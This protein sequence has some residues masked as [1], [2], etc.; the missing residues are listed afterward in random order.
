[1]QS[2]NLNLKKVAL[3]ILLIA[4]FL[5]PLMSFTFAS[6][7]PEEAPNGPWVDEIVFFEEPDENKV[8]DMLEKGDA[9][10]YL[11]LITDPANFEKVKKSPNIDYRIAYGLYNELTFNPAEFVTGFNPFHNKRIRE[12]MNYIVDREYIANEIMHGMAIPKWVSIIS[13][14]PEYGRLADVIKAIEF[15]YRYNFEKGKE[16]VFEEMKK[17][18]A[19]FKDG[20]WYYNGEPVVIK[21]VIRTEDERK[22]IG[23]YFASQL[24]KLGFTVERL[25]KSR[26][27]ASPIVF[28]SDPRQGEWHVYTGGWISTTIDVVNNWDP[29]FFYTPLGYGTYMQYTEPDP[30]LMEV[31][32]K[33]WNGEYKTEEER[34]EL[35]REA[36]ILCMKDSV[37]I[38]LVDQISP[39]PFRSEL[40]V[41]ADL[42]GGF[43]G[44]MWLRTIRF[45]D[46]VGGTVKAA[47][48]G[49][50]V[51][52]WN[53]VAGTN[54][55][56]DSLVMQATTDGFVV[57]HPFLGG[58]ISNRAE[59][60][61]EQ[62]PEEGIPVP[63]DAY[64]KWDTEARKWV[65]VGEGVK[66][67]AKVTFYNIQWGPYH[68]GTQMTIA[69]IMNGI[70]M[71][72]ELV[73]PD[74]PLFDEEVQ[75]T[76]GEWLSLFKGIRIVDDNTIEIYT[77]Y[78]ELTEP[79]YVASWADVWASLPWHVYA[80]MNRAVAKERLA[81][82][83][84][85]SETKG[86]PWLNLIAGESLPI[87]EEELEGLIAESYVPDWLV[88]FGVTQDEAAARYAALKA[89]YEE[90]GHFWAGNG[91]YYLYM[92][93]FT[94]HQ[95]SVRAF[96]DYP[97]KADK[98]AYLSE[99]PVPKTTLKGPE[100]LM[101]ASTADYDIIIKLGDKPYPAAWISKVT[102][103]VL[104]AEANVVAKGEGT[105]L[106]D[107]L[108]RIRL[109]PIVT[110]APGTYTM[111]VV[112]TSTQIAMP[113]VVE[114]S[115]TVESLKA[116]IDNSLAT[117][118]SELQA[119]VSGVKSD[120][121]GV[122]ADLSGEIEALRA[123][124]G[125]IQMIAIVAVI[126][127]IIA[128]ALPFVVKK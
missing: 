114:T 25:F 41:A 80:M 34:L 46:K 65:K 112:V 57:T 96:R 74:G 113:S 19:E 81:Y 24:E 110:A 85:A 36:L 115:I 9:H 6:A 101:Q 103:L 102:Y 82:S 18:G 60:E 119:L 106:E 111:L 54:W 68:D 16:I 12:A 107:G 117:A 1:M 32:T 98:F 123:Q 43:S 66:A 127:A 22:F 128:V 61:V 31:S 28:A 42:S 5:L 120:L 67:K 88:E 15:K 2:K 30:R 90:R 21:V 71:N 69:D 23:D 91:P 63:P 108:A 64:A 72:F 58:Y 44:P 39:Y 121:Q 78:T 45:K 47:S 49:V 109:D 70:A 7:A 35:M 14:F 99:P 77:D 93:D 62:N 79:S 40:S 104:D 76:V 20:K 48:K 87:L 116:Y 56:Y 13:A 53:P 94:A 59:F 8:I 17:M 100:T 27:E 75:D 125:T 105:V 26:K 38:F 33:L 84:T 83:S 89:F 97:M 55:L 3:S 10:I 37:R 4:L 95:A 50:L 122:K 11:Y 73:D 124:L 86:L 51:D 118:K 92:A 29:G 52:P 126:I